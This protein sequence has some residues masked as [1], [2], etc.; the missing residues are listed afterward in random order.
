MLRVGKRGLRTGRFL[1]LEVQQLALLH[2]DNSF[3][4]QKVPERILERKV[5]T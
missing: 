1:A 2:L 5:H 3:K 4:R